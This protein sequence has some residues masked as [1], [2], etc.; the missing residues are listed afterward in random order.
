M[1][2]MKNVC[3]ILVRK[4]EGKRPLGRPRHTC[5][6]KNN[7]G[8]VV[9]IHMSKDQWQALVNTIM[10]P[11]VLYIVGNSL[12]SDRFFLTTVSAHGCSFCL[13]LQML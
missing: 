8:I 3:K 10:N 5:E 9:W 4:S 13:L 7:K 11:E 2:D 6:E 1:G 12:P